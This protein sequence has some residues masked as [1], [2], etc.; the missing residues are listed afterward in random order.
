[1][2]LEPYIWDDDIPTVGHGVPPE[3]TAIVPVGLGG[4]GLNPADVISVEPNGI[5]VGET[6]DAPPS[7]EVAPIA[8]V[9]TTIPFI[10]A[11]ATLPTSIAG[12]AAAIDQNLICTLR[13]PNE[14]PRAC[15]ASKAGIVALSDFLRCCSSRSKRGF[16]ARKSQED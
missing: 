2:A 14:L 8:G 1:M 5:P 7:G 15:R 11:R 16:T 6:D 13:L 10:C 4:R 12:S 9:G 3:G